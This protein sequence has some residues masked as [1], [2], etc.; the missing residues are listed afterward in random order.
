VLRRSAA[1]LSLRTQLILGALH[2]M[3]F[4]KDRLIRIEADAM[5]ETCISFGQI[6]V[7]RSYRAGFTFG[8]V[9]VHT[10]LQACAYPGRIGASCRVKRTSTSVKSGPTQRSRR[11]LAQA[12]SGPRTASSGLHLRSN[13][14]RRNA[15]GVHLLGPNRGLYAASSGL[16]LRSNQD[17]RSAPGM[18]L[19]GLNRGLYAAS[20]GLFLRSRR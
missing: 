4:H 18:R 19:L 7:L 5:L 16:P 9:K 12:K 11:A 20:S 1:A 10:A 14:D 8:W 15:P 2:L 3:C 6:A 17:R 13:Q